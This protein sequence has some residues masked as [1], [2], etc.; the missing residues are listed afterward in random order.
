MK[1]E[2]LRAE[3]YHRLLSLVILDIDHLKKNNDA[4]GHPAGNEVLKKIA[5]MLK[6]EAR[7]VDIVAR[8]G[9]E[10]MVIILPET[11]RKRATDLAE[12]IR[13]RVSDALFDHMQSQPLGKMTVSAG[14]A[15]FPVDASTE[16]D[17]I[18]KAD[19]SLYQAKSQGRNQVVAFKV[20]ITYRPHREISKVAL[21][22]SFNNWDK[23]TDLMPR[24]EDGSFR[25]VIALNPGIYHYKFVLNDVEW[26]ADPS[27]PERVH[28]GLGG[29]NSVLRVQG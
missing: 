25:F 4:N 3:R 7:E 29:D 8:Y 12:R 21:V 11:S 20:P 27:C 14:V 13:Q 23:D 18:K 17:L 15:T 10:E 1:E 16:D 19:N 2:R 22:G 26:I 9:G 28:D 6:Q 24:Q 5:T